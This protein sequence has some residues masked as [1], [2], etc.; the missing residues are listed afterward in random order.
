[1]PR[2]IVVRLLQGLVTLFVLAT[3]VFILARLIGNPVDMMLP[4]GASLAQREAMIHRL[5]LDRPVY[6]QY[7]EFMFGLVRG[8]LGESI[9]FDVPV[10]QLFMSRF[11]ATLK[12]TAVAI[13]IALGAGFVLGILS[14]THKGGPIDHFSRAI[15]VIG[16]SAPSF[17]LG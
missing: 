6:V 1:M 8:D 17:W 3:L 12:L 16:M 4:P 14:A 5:G 7:R 13:A 15:S 2:Y 9:K 10:L 11:P